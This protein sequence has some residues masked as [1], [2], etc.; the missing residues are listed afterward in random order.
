MFLLWR[1]FNLLVYVSQAAIEAAGLQAYLPTETTVTEVEEVTTV[2]VPQEEEE[3][4]KEEQKS[5]TQM[6][7]EEEEEES[8]QL[9]R[10][11]AL[12]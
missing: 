3:D 4:D 7:D 10:L 12:V 1:V 6:R 2:G 8:V 11:D 5:T 9:A